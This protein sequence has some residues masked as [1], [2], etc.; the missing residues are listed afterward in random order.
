MAGCTGSGGEGE[1][2]GRALGLRKV[3]QLVGGGRKGGARGATVAS[4]RRHFV[5]CC[6]RWGV[7]WDGVG[8]SWRPLEVTGWPRREGRV[9]EVWEREAWIFRAQLENLSR[10]RS[11]RVQYDAGRQDSNYTKRGIVRGEVLEMYERDNKV[12]ERGNDD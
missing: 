2:E 5:R 10:T 12:R 11:S 7:G 4:G 9:C 3:G 1:A 6:A 8:G